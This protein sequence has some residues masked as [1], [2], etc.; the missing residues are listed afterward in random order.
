[1]NVNSAPQPSSLP[2]RCADVTPY[3]SAY[4]DG[5]LAQPLRAQIAAHLETCESCQA[6]VARYA[7]IDAALMT[8]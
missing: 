1:M 2:L 5:E 4:A 6:Q 3:L 8:L 7:G